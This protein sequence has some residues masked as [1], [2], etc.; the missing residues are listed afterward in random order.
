MAIT[1]IGYDGSV[2]ETAWTKLMGRAAGNMYGVAGPNDLKVTAHPTLA[3]GIVIGAG[4]GWGHGVYDTS[5]ATATLQGADIVS[6]I[7]WDMVVARRNWT[8]AG[9]ATSFVLLTGTSTKALVSRSTTPGSIDDQPLALVQFS[10]GT[11]APTA[12][13]DLRVWP[14]SG[15]LYATDLMARDYNTAIGS[16]LLINGDDW[17]SVL[18]SGLQ[19]WQRQSSMQAIQLFGAGTGILGGTP[20]IVGNNFYVQAGTNVAFSDGS[21]YARVT[22]PTPFPNGLLTVILTNGAADVDRTLGHVVTLTPAGN[23]RDVGDKSGV[24]YAV[25]CEDSTGTNRLYMLGNFQHRVNYIAIG[26]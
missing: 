7:R 6:G 19:A 16:R 3:R 11:T 5:D 13:V 8:G 9:G 14:G 25:A 10:A 21:G 18:A 17:I 2:D 24:S 4:S 12:I 22:F 1:S 26:W 20:A 23:P 15:G